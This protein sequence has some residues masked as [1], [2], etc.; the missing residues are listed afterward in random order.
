MLD[1]SNPTHQVLTLIRCALEYADKAAIKNRLWLF[2]LTECESALTA[3]LGIDQRQPLPTKPIKS[4][5]VS[6]DR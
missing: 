1:L 3:E 6:N 5:R 4:K 2:F